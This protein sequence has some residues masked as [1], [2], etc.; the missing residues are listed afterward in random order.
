[1]MKAKLLLTDKLS[2]VYRPGEILNV[3]ETESRQA[4]ELFRSLA[5]SSPEGIYIVQDGKFC[6][7][8][9]QFQK[10]TGYKESELIGMEPLSL[11]KDEDRETV[12]EKTAMMLK[13]KR[14]SPYE[15]RVVDKDGSV[16][17]ILETVAPI[18]YGGRPAT[19]ANC[20][21]ITER[22]DMEKKMVEYEELDR[23]KGSILSTVSHELRTP[24]SIIKGYSTLLIDYS[25]RLN[26][27]EKRDYLRSID[28]ATDRL[29]ELV[30]H[31]LDMSR[32]EAGL[33][34]LEKKTTSISNLVRKAIAEASLR[35]SQHEIEAR[36]S[37]R[38]PRVQADARRIRQVLD[39]LIDNAIKYSAGG[40]TVT[41]E[42]R[43][44]ESNVQISVA[45][46]GIGIPDEELGKVFDRM[47]RIEQR[48][49]PDK[50][51]IGLGLAI[52]RGLVESHGGRIWVESEVGQGSTFYFT[53]PCDR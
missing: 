11:V 30:D 53:L 26:P 18:K 48:L 44:V 20:I 12:R 37:R 34:R 4:E 38:L 45:D 1:M 2:G 23:L 33:L 5:F 6:F 22:K 32:L 8:N 13:G 27:D 40:T 7:V 35:A 3:T 46:R 24:L 41:V 19:V 10:D 17:W 16:R 9:P 43:Q 14:S 49:T 50:G 28:M 21:D 52:C 29:T 47:Y 15:F 25:Q 31:I 42:A 36:V 51:G 39:N